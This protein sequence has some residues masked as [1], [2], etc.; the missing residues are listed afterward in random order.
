MGH[1]NK[2]NTVVARKNLSVA[3][4]KVRASTGRHSVLQ[5]IKIKAA[6]VK[7]AARDKT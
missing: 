5:G 1:S 4:L 7:W 3:D 2:E 6:N